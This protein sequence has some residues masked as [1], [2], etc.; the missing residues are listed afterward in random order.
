M[1]LERVARIPNNPQ[2]LTLG[3]LITGVHAHAP[4]AQMREQDLDSS[5][6]EHHVIPGKPGAVGIGCWHGHVRSTC[7]RSTP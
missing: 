1:R 4:L 2:Q 3:H 7:T 6:L 5:A